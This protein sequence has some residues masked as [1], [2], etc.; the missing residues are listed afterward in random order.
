MAST[1]GVVVDVPVGAEDTHVDFA[2]VGDKRLEQLLSV[3]RDFVNEMAEA[4]LVT[5]QSEPVLFHLA[6]G[7]LER[8]RWEKTAR[9]ESHRA[10]QF[11]LF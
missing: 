5:G 9:I 10:S 3:T 2:R 8:L 4:S 7:F 1:R 6:S 11:T